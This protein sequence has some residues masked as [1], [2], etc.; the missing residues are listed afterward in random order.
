MRRSLP[1]LL[2]AATAIAGCASKQPTAELVDARVAY[3]RA[4]QGTAARVNPAGLY[5]AKR[6]LD[7]AEKAQNDDPGSGPA[8]DTAYVALRKAQLAEANARTVVTQTQEQAAIAA[9]HET[10]AKALASTKERLGDDAKMLQSEQQARA[11]AET[12]A[13]QAME[14]L[15]AIASIK[16]GPQG[17]TVITL[18]GGVLFETGKAEL[19]PTAR[20]R[21]NQVAE[22]LKQSDGR[23]VEVVGYTDNVGNDEK[24]RDLSRRRAEAVKAYLVTQQVPADLLTAKGQGK[25]NP[26]A[27]N[28]NAEGRA[29]NRRVELVIEGASAN[30]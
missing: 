10:Q 7:A 2:L 20:E 28:T 8:K 19:L 26:I 29:M 24:N 6:A 25:D 30:K 4:T 14:S 13:K 1:V 17:A 21:L 9:L 11:A 23:K 16:Q 18:P 15:V 5:D 12:K 3:Q 22:A 27:D